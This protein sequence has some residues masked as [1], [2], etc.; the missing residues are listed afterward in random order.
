MNEETFFIE[1]D[2][3]KLK[4][5]VK[6]SADLT[7]INSTIS[8]INN[9]ISPIVNYTTNVFT[10]GEIA[11]NSYFRCPSIQITNNNVVVAISDYRIGAGED[12]SPISIVCKRSLDFGRTWSES[13]VVLARHTMNTG[14]RV[15]DGNLLYN[16]VT[17]RLFLFGRRE[18]SNIDWFGATSKT[19]LIED[20]VYTYSDDDGLTWSAEISLSSLVPLDCVCMGQSYGTGI[21][22]KNGYLVLPIFKNT[23]NTSARLQSGILLSTD[24]GVTW[25]VKGFIPDTY[26]ETNEATV[27]ETDD[28]VIL[29]NCR[30]YISKRRVFITRDF[31]V[32]YET[33]TTDQKII[34]PLGCAGTA[35]KIVNNGDILYAFCNPQNKSL[36]KN[37]SVQLSLDCKNWVTSYTYADDRLVNGYSVLATRNSKLLLVTEEYGTIVFHDISNI[38]Y[39]KNLKLYNYISQTSSNSAYS[40]KLMQTASKFTLGTGKNASLVDVDISE[41]VVNGSVDFTLEGNSGTINNIDSNFL[42]KVSGSL[43]E[44]PNILKGNA[45]IALALPADSGFGE[46]STVGY[47]SASS[48]NGVFKDNGATTNL[49][50]PQQLFSFNIISIYENKYGTI[51]SAD[52]TMASKITWLK[53]NIYSL[54]CNWYGYGTC[55][56]GNK[57]SVKFLNG[58]AWVSG[59]SVIS[60]TTSSVAN[61]TVSSLFVNSFLNLDCIDS[62]GLFHCLAYSDATDGTTASH[63]LTDFVNLTISFNALYQSVGENKG[64]TGIH[65]IIITSNSKDATSSD[66]KIINLINPLR[67]VSTTVA[68]TYSKSK[69]TRKIKSI[70]G[71]ANNTVINFADMLT[72]GTY[73]AY[74][75]NGEY[76]TGIK[77]ET[78]TFTNSSVTINYQLTT[79]IV[80]TVDLKTSTDLIGVNPLKAYQGGNVSISSG[81]TIPTTYYTV[82]VNASA[83]LSDYYSS[84]NISKDYTLDSLQNIKNRTY[85]DFLS[86][87]AIYWGSTSILTGTI[88]QVSGIQLHPGIIGYTSSTT[89]NSGY[90]CITSQ[91]STL[92]SGGEKSTIIFKTAT[93]LLGVTRYMGFHNTLDLTAPTNGV[94][95]KIADGVLTGNVANTSVIST[96]STSYTVEA[97]TWYRLVIELNSD[98]TSATYKLYADNSATVLLET[99]LSASI[100]KTTGKEIGHGDVCTYSGTSAVTIG[101]LDYIDII[102]PNARRII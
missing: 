39:N 58:G 29:I 78:L 35:V 73:V 77:G 40:D 79:P 93:T 101:Y 6:N 41:S 82:P 37:Y 59:G 74:N 19:G 1:E 50:I 55:P 92:L 61:I 11:S 75:S 5:Q 20:F 68:D 89:A 44:N 4:K 81:L 7:V 83:T 16:K 90:R 15:M 21:Q 33:H 18:D 56:S 8:N 27:V 38:I 24:N 99:T 30:G 67:R 97:N 13:I 26:G 95:V 54:D 57:A 23:S 87:S 60:N 22:L 64:G 62:T 43:V 71:Q 70:T 85:N 45:N 49:Q 36:R 84:L 9:E 66:S 48:L 65:K 31:G 14:S 47:T 80:E 72:G 32:T 91:T 46:T 100:P 86:T 3:R 52:E 53:N 10:K 42:G 51:P 102:L 2:I 76:K 94:Y 63:I 28:N 88:T 96:A 12:T 69:V 34:E 25:A 17:G 98:A